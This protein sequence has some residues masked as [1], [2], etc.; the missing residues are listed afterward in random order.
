MLLNKALLNNFYIIN[1]ILLYYIYLFLVPQ[2]EMIISEFLDINIKAP[3]YGGIE[4]A[5]IYN[6]VLLFY[7]PWQHMHK[8]ILWDPLFTC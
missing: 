2:K 5:E 8:C 6:K 4:A 3:I 7:F 1:I